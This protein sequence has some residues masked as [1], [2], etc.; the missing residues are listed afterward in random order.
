MALFSPQRLTMRKRRP[1]RETAVERVVTA[2]LWCQGW[3]LFVRRHGIYKKEKTLS[4]SLDPLIGS[5]PS[6]T[7]GP[8]PWSSPRS[9]SFA[10]VR[11]RETEKAALCY[12]SFSGARLFAKNKP[13]IVSSLSPPRELLFVWGDFG[14]SAL[15]V[16]G[17]AYL[18]NSG[19]E[20][21]NCL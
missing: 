15:F 6:P 18:S 3:R 10:W 14:H 9:W 12:P 19:I 11:S 13:S 4:P 16:P 1:R 8:T 17:K 7:M 2:V 20:C 5:S 21:Y